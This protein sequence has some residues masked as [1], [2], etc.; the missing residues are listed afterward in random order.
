MRVRKTLN[1]LFV[2]YPSYQQVSDT[3]TRDFKDLLGGAEF[4]ENISLDDNGLG[5]VEGARRVKQ[6]N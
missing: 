3:V 4:R 6:V 1:H 2:Q 5:L